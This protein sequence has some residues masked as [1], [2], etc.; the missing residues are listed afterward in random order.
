MFVQLICL[1]VENSCYLT[2]YLDF[3]AKLVPG[4]PIEITASRKPYLTLTYERFS[5]SEDE[6]SICKFKPNL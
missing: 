3:K 1:L 2:C 6:G 5:C 4:L